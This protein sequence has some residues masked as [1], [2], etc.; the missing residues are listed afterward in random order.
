MTSP[1]RATTI[2]V[3]VLLALLVVG[4]AVSVTVGTAEIDVASVY[5]IIG[6][7]L[8]GKTAAGRPDVTWSAA[9]ETIVV[10]LRLPRIL[11]ALFTGAA[12]SVT[13]AVLQGIFR[14]PMA[15]PYVLGVS[16]GAAL[17]VSLA[18]VF[19]AVHPLLMQASAFV[20]ALGSLVLVLA[21]AAAAGGARNSFSLLLSGIAV[22][23]FLSAVISLIMYLNHERAEA[24]LFWTF[25]SLGTSSWTTVQFAVPTLGIG[26]IALLFHGRRLNVLMQGD[27][28]ARSLGMV[29]GAG[30]LVLLA[31]ASLITAAAVSVAGIIGF[32]GLLIPHAFRLILGPDNRYLM[33]VAALGGAFFLLVAD[34][35]GRVVLAPSEVPVGIITALVGAPYLLLLLALRRRGSL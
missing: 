21:I 24:I 23:L 30:R 32:V 14:N 35:I 33:P 13:G 22:S 9:A 5:R 26:V 19:G 11:I 20:G 12:L 8:A 27:D 34:T 15:D 4:V 29:P 7:R 18:T 31:F 17:G 10:R 3:L 16:A 1:A 28:T 25:G 6:L 2:T